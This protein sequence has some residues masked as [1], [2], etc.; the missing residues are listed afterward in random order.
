MLAVAIITV[1]T[2]VL[3]FISPVYRVVTRRGWREAART[4]SIMQFPKD[5][6]RE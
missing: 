1:D 6:P 5:E 4:R 3:L 2:I